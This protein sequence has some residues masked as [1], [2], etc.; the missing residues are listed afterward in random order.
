MRNNINNLYSYPAFSGMTKSAAGGTAGA[1]RGLGSKIW[2]WVKFP[3][4]AGVGGTGA[5]H[6]NNAVNDP[7]DP[8]EDIVLYSDDPHLQQASYRVLNYMNGKEDKNKTANP[9][10]A[11]PEQEVS[12]VSDFFDK[13]PALAWTGVGALGLGALGLGAYAMS[14]DDDD[15]DEKRKYYSRHTP[16][17]PRY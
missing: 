5:W 14:D 13:H 6:I 16:P 17:Y 8:L 10:T 7:K 12:S 2:D 4:F 9:A 1:T 11:N 3:L 15:E